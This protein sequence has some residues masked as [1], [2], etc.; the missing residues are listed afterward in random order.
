MKIIDEDITGWKQDDIDLEALAN[1]E[2]GPQI[3]IDEKKQ[4]NTDFS[5]K[6]LWKTVGEDEDNDKGATNSSTS[7]K[8]KSKSDSKS[9]G[10]LHWSTAKFLRKLILHWLRSI[11]VLRVHFE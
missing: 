8:L 6:T 1:C 3:V 10:K 7:G 9:Q 4:K 5:N 2:D 11:I